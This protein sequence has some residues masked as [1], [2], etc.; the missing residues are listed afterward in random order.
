MKR[1]LALILSLA[2]VVGV[3]SLALAEGDDNAIVNGGF[4]TGDLTGWT[5]LTY[6][7]GEEPSGVLSADTYWN[8]GM[9][10]NQAGAFHLDGWNTG[11][12]EGEAWAIRSTDFVL[13][14]VGYITVR[15]GGNAAAVRVYRSDDNTLVGYY[16]QTRFKNERFPQVGAEGG[17]WADMGTYIIDLREYVGEK[18]YIV[19]SDEG[20]GDWGQAFFDEVVTYYEAVPQAEELVD[21]VKD[22][23]TGE[24]VALTP[25][26]AENLKDD[27][28]AEL[29]LPEPPAPP[30]PINTKPLPVDEEKQVENYGFESGDL[31][32]WYVLSDRWGTDEGG[33][34]TG[35][36]SADSYWNEHLP[37]NQSDS[38]HLDGWNT[39][40][41]ENDIWRVRSQTFTL[42]GAGCISVKMGGNAAAVRV[43][44]EDG[45]LIGYYRQTRF[46]DKNFPS[47]LRGGSWADMATYVIDLEDYVGER[48]YVELCDEKDNGGWAQAFFDEVVTHYDTAPNVKKVEDVVQNGGTKNRVSIP[49]QKATNLAVVTPAENRLRNAGFELGT[50]EGWT[51]DR[52]NAIGKDFNT[53]KAIS[54]AFTYWAEKLPY[55][56][57]GR[58]HLDGA[59][60][61]AND[62]A[63]WQLKSDA[64]T[65]G[66]SG[67]VSVKMGGK[68]AG[69]RVY[70]ADT[71]EMIGYF[72]QNRFNDQFFN[73]GFLAAGGSWGDMGTYVLD[74]SEYVGRNVYIKLADEATGGWG[75]ANFDDLVTYYETA[76]DVES[77]YDLVKNGNSYDTVAIP[78]QLAENYAIL[79]EAERSVINGNFETGDLTGWTVLTEGFH[80][81]TAV[82]SATTYWGEELPYNQEG[83][84]HLDGW[85]TGIAENGT[86]AIRSS[87]FTL[88]GSGWITIRMGGHA[89]AVRVYQKAEA[90]GADDTLIGYYKQQ[91]FNDAN[92]PSLS[93][94]GSWADMRTHMMDLSDYLGKRLYLELRD[95][96]VGGWAHAFFDDVVTYYE[97][98]PDWETHYD[99]VNDGHI[100]GQPPQTPVEVQLPWVLAPNEVAAVRS[101][102]D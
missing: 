56:Q 10:Y 45:T 97:E 84:Y 53:E 21:M 30:K 49:W 35:V 39:G 18:L 86:W 25:V 37:Y 79:D 14:G 47:L 44:L 93:Q 38:Y 19:L 36:I 82:T 42:D 34:Y 48:M 16:R 55:N 33:N 26:M 60:A 31:S 76:P 100:N 77:L 40:I 22:P 89:A 62:D 91:T 67:F 80:A 13:G 90:E 68:G 46:A 1:V 98:A 85:N 101:V 66:G 72:R 23:A 54:D 95:E 5:P 4:E 17:S 92:F 61:I 83:S 6:N 9:P 43:Y 51:L 8:E 94:G 41:A 58:F 87:E 59:A 69:V 88:G 64:F 99:T 63:K 11:I 70:D 28:A 74:L 96:E 50:L 102:A 7:W 52:T 29:V 24:M 32:G 15:M 71:N 12:A 3:P 75:M 81:D 2:M 27:P 73:N 78:W 65:L 57:D 20:A